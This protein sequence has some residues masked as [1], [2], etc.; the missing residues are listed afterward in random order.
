MLAGA[1]PNSVAPNS[2]AQ[3]GALP[4]QLHAEAFGVRGAAPAAP[5]FVQILVHAQSK[6]F[7]V[8]LDYTRAPDGVLRIERLIVDSP[9]LGAATLKKLR[10]YRGDSHPHQAQKPQDIV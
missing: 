2:V 4:G 7:S 9:S 8:L 1:A 5:A 10:I 6:P 3:D